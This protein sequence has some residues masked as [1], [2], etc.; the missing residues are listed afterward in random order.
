M[1][2]ELFDFGGVIISLI[3]FLNI[4]IIFFF[5]LYLFNSFL[6]FGA[7]FTKLVEFCL[8]QL[9]HMLN[10][11]FQLIA[12]L[13]ECLHHTLRVRRFWRLYDEEVAV[14]GPQ[15]FFA[16]ALI[17]IFDLLDQFTGTIL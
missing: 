10:L 11:G 16:V 5:T 8:T 15:L 13:S 2:G 6:Q 12:E 17:K 4:N 3:F 7:Q 14:D 9:G 1:L